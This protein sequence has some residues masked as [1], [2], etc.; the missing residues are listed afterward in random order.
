MRSKQLELP[1]ASWSLIH[2]DKGM[3]SLWQGSAPDPIIMNHEGSGFKGLVFCAM[4]YQPPAV[5]F[6]KQAFVIHAPND[7]SAKQPP[8]KTQI[9]EAI[10]ASKRVARWVQNGAS[11]LVTCYLGLNRSGLVSALA[12]HFL[13][14]C[15]G[16]VAL[17][18]VREA[19]GSRA[20]SNPHFAEFLQNIKAQDPHSLNVIPLP[21]DRR[22]LGGS[23]R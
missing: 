11:V 9:V 15:S 8:T 13:T 3:G 22:A 6:P 5:E 7:D 4:E 20:L 19:R 12:L 1:P 10:H 14:G 21:G 17:W 23:T 16:E 18:K 2:R